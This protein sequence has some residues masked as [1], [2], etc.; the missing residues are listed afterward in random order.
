[1]PGVERDLRRHWAGV[2][3]DVAQKGGERRRQR[4]VE[5]KS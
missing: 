3:A 1:M 5:T 2:E 4:D